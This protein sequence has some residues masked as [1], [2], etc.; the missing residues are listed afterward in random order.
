MGEGRHRLF[1]TLVVMGAVLGGC[2]SFDDA[3]SEDSAFQSPTVPRNDF[4]VGGSAFAG[5]GSVVPESQSGGIPL[6][7]VTMPP[8][9][10][11]DADAG[12]DDDAG[13]LPCEP[14][15]CNC[16]FGRPECAGC[17]VI[18]CAIT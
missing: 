11:A 3:P 14:A 8:V 10:V 4:G 1:N 9:V 12:T 7:P 13:A 15:A 5:R 17:E 18:Y 6:P 2:N 16:G